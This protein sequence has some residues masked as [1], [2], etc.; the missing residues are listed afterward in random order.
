MPTGNITFILATN[1]YMDVVNRVHSRQTDNP[2]S[3]EAVARV[4]DA[5]KKARE[6]PHNRVCGEYENPFDSAAF[7]SRIGLRNMFFFMPHG[8]EQKKIIA[9]HRLEAKYDIL[10]EQKRFELFWEKEVPLWFAKEVKSARELEDLV[11]EN[12][13]NLLTQPKVV[14]Y[15]ER[16]AAVVI[17]VRGEKL[18][19]SIGEPPTEVDGVC[20]VD[21][22]SRQAT[23]PNVQS[24]SATPAATSPSGS[25]ASSSSRERDSIVERDYIVERDTE[26]FVKRIVEHVVNLV[27]DILAICVDPE[28]LVEWDSLPEYERLVYTVAAIVALMVLYNF[29]TMLITVI[30]ELGVSIAVGLFVVPIV[31]FAVLYWVAPELAIQ[32]LKFAKAGV[33]LVYKYRA[34]LWPILAAVWVVEVGR[35]IFSFF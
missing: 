30:P 19:I 17:Y 18:D 10:W 20:R 34:W 26:F 8:L 32:V 27:R 4:K 35:F 23:Q 33:T 14:K 2:Y 9:N 3:N 15:G 16:S 5:V 22:D 13:N 7:F 28:T 24:T 25:D 12:I 21:P 29:V 1:C 31:L 6:N 11:E